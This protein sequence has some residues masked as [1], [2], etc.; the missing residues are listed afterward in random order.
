MDRPLRK[1]CLLGDYRV[2]KTRLVRQLTHCDAAPPEAGVHLHFWRWA[3]APE[4]EFAVFDVA[5]RSALD[6]V[7][8]SF[9]AGADGFVLV[10][11]G[12]Q[13]DSIPVALQLFRVAQ[14]L[15]GPRPSILILNKADR[16]LA[17][18]GQV[19]ADLPVFH[20]SARSGDGVQLAFGALAG[21]VLADTHPMDGPLAQRAAGVS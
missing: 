3:G 4:V 2:G 14:G 20:V 18:L 21:R 19:P 15:V 9:L 7:G 6:S 8:Q 5:G 1:L 17:A 10:A 13:P 12:S 11:D 16:G